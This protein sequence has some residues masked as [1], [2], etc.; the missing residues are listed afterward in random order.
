M[1]LLNIQL[2]LLFGL[3]LIGLVALV[4]QDERIEAIRFEITTER[5]RAQAQENE[6]RG[7][8][9]DNAKKCRDVLASYMRLLE[10]VH[11]ELRTWPKQAVKDTLVKAPSGPSKGQ[12]F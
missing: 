2:F 7:N 5:A 1:K 3:Q 8:V 10:T 6:L 9:I 11:P 4:S 12:T